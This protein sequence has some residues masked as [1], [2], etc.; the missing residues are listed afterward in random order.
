MEE[1]SGTSAVAPATGGKVEAA[2]A[3][4]A[5]AVVSPAAGNATLEREKRMVPLTSDSPA[6]V[7]HDS[8]AP[9]DASAAEVKCPWGASR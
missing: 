8:S 1:M 3:A 7:A 5:A 9:Q 2:M 6:S 4:P